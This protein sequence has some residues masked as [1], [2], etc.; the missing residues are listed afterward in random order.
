MAA[1]HSIL[2]DIGPVFLSLAIAVTVLAGFVK[3]AV[4]FALPMIMISGLGSFLPPEV[5][6]AALILPTVAANL[7]QALR[8]GLTAA[9]ASVWRFR[10]YMAIVLVFIA[11][12]AQLVQVLPS[13]VL[14][15]ILG[16]PVTIFA[17]A[18]LLGWRLYLK[19]EHRRRAEVIIGAIAGFIGGMS[20]IWGP[21]TVAYLTALDTPKTEQMRVQGVVYGAG[22]L[23]LLAAHLKSGVLNAETAPLSALLLVPAL[24]GVA[25]GI[26]VHD[27]LDQDRFRKAT[28]AVLVIAGLNLVR[29]GLTG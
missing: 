27:R 28:L 3:G 22:A 16:V 19:P 24:V 2:P 20:G 14:Y 10:L 23:V 5:A 15:L 25:L 11:G 21:P 13:W 12:S 17:V 7:W 1:M 26:L 4:G 18:Q 29:R 9:L 6:L 8:D